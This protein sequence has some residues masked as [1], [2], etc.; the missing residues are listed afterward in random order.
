VGWSHQ[1]QREVTLSDAGC[2]LKRD[3]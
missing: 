3:L 2:D 1:A